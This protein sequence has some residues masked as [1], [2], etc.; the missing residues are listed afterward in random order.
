MDAKSGRVL[1]EDAI[2]P[3]IGLPRTASLDHGRLRLAYRRAVNLDCSLVQDTA[4]CWGK[5]VAAGQAPRDLPR[6]TKPP[7]RCWASYM[8]TAKSDPSILEYQLELTL[9]A[10]GHSTVI[11]QGPV[12]PRATTLGRMGVIRTWLAAFAAAALLAGPTLAPSLAKAAD[13]WLTL[14]RRPPLPPAAAWRGDVPTTARA[15]GYATYGA[16]LA[17]DP[18]ARRPRQQ[19]LLGRPGPGRS[20]PTTTA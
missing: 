3:T 20:S 8:H 19:R 11:S 1:F 5:A 17:G 10:A 9:D 13:R 16:G 12:D 15:S 18:A 2:A 4:A 14:P 6:L 7:K